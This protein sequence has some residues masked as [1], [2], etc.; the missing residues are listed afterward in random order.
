MFLLMN[1]IRQAAWPDRAGPLPATTP[2]APV[3]AIR[4]ET[5]QPGSEISRTSHVRD[6]TSTVLPMS[7]SDVMTA[8]SID[9][10]VAR[11]LAQPDGLPPAGDVAGDDLARD[12]PALGLGRRTE[13]GPGARRYPAKGLQVA[14]LVP[15][16]DQFGGHLLVLAHQ[17][18]DAADGPDALPDPAGEAGE[19]AL[20]GRDALPQHGLGLAGHG[21]GQVEHHEKHGAQNH[22]QYDTSVSH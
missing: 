10:A 19:R 15:Q 21:V 17:A 16:A 20:Q 9:D 6:E 18:A 11:P 2:N 22:P 1:S 13:A 7:P 4:A 12:E 14:H 8:M 5:L 3:R